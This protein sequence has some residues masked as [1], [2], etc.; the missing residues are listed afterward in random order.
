MKKRYFSPELADFGT[1]GLT[2]M[3]SLDGVTDG[4]VEIS[5][6]DLFG[7]DEG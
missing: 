2:T 3:V 4:E 7:V 6:G 5:G 1:D